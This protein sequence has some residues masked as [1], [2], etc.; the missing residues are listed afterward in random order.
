[1]WLYK[2]YKYR[3]PKTN[4][5]KNSHYTLP[6]LILYLLHTT[7]NII[8]S[9]FS[10]LVTCSTTI[11]SFFSSFQRDV[12]FGSLGTAFQY[13]WQGTG[14]DHPHTIKDAQQSMHWARLAAQNNPH[15]LTILV[16]PDTH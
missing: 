10:S 2:R 4:P 16:M 11:S 7:F 12:I 13:K 5:L 15:N 1:M 6:N 3:V 14:F 9:Y 8:H